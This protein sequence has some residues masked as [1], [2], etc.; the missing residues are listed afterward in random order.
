LDYFLVDEELHKKKDAVVDSIINSD[1]IGSDH[2]PIQLIISH[3][4]IW[5]NQIKQ[6]SENIYLHLLKNN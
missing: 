3:K 1:I 6:K 2:T 5:G 4:N